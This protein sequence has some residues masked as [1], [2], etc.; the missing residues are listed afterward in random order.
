MINTARKSLS[1]SYIQTTLPF[2]TITSTKCH[3]VTSL[4]IPAE[5]GEEKK[6]ALVPSAP[7]GQRG[8]REQEE[9]GDVK[10]GVSCVRALVAPAFASN[11]NQSE[12]S[13]WKEGQALK[14][15]HCLHF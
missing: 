10:G 15:A 7:A 5:C 13:S 11:P 2:W 12:G 3:P 6:A 1:C 8:G 9:L 14:R 4:S